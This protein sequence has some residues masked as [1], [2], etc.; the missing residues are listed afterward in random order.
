MLQK[1]PA[2]KVT[3]WVNE[4][5]KHHLEPLWM[6]VFEYLR[7]KRIAGASVTHTKLSFGDRHRTHNADAAETA[8][9]SY[10]VEFVESPERVEEVLPTLYEMVV[11]GLIEVHDTV[12]V[13]AVN[14][15][16]PAPDPAPA[17]VRSQQRA[18]LMRI[19][20]GE[21]D[22][23]HGEPLYDAIVMRL[24]MMDIAGATVYRGIMGYGT[25][26][27]THRPHLLHISEDLPIVISVVDTPRKIA[28]AEPVVEAML[29]DGLIVVSDVD[30]IRLVHPK[31]S[32]GEALP[33]VER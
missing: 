16:R 15:D 8:E 30:T 10:R 17:A 27:E 29:Q 25:K 12:V 1:G 20:L 13:K 6:A 7:H 28:E 19:F 26:G 14:K 11:D 3:V 31:I 24:R 32:I 2:K 4:D 18:K 33:N 5:T 9:Y 21:R 22:Q 23:W